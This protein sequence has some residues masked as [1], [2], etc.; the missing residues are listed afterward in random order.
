MTSGSG[1]G[2]RLDDV[3]RLPLRKATGVVLATLDAPSEVAAFR[4]M[5]HPPFVVKVQAAEKGL[6]GW[7]WRRG[8]DD[9]QG[10]LR[11]GLAR[12]WAIGHIKGD[13]FTPAPQRFTR[14]QGFGGI[15]CVAVKPGGVVYEVDPSS[16]S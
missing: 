11:E 3:S 8:H 9:L 7:R 5:F 4:C 14:N 13:A 1:N 16:S 12:L 10:P 15:D 2:L 6:A